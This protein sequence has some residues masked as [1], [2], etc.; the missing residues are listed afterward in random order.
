MELG[1][2]ASL[3]DRLLTRVEMF[4]KFHAGFSDLKSVLGIAIT[5]NINP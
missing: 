2:G 1:Q 3:S 4:R 5:L